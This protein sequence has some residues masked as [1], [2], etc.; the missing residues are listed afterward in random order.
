MAR[1]GDEL[2]WLVTRGSSR[3]SMGVER[4]GDSRS[5]SGAALQGDALGQVLL[6]CCAGSCGK[7]VH[8]RKM[9]PAAI[10]PAAAASSVAR[11]G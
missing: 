8:R 7:P 11:P 5:S 4:V 3:S 6:T 2:R 9:R 10:Q 1:V